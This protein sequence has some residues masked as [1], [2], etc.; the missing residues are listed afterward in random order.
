MKR[1]ADDKPVTKNGAQLRDYLQFLAYSGAREQ[2]ALRVRWSDV[3]LTTGRVTIGADGL[4]KNHLSRTV[5]FNAQLENLLREMHARRAPDSSW[6]FPSP[7]RGARDM[8]AKSFRESLK[9]ART[10]AKLPR[11]GFHDLRHMFA[12][13]CVMAGIDFMTIAAWMGHKDGGILVGKVYGHLLDA[14]RRNM[15]Q[16]VQFGLGR[17]LPREIALTLRIFPG[18]QL[19]P[20]AVLSAMTSIVFNRGSEL[21]GDR[22]REMLAIQQLIQRFAALSSTLRERELPL[23]LRDIAAQIRSMKRL[24]QGEGLADLLRRREAEAHGRVSGSLMDLPPCQ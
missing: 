15:A 18:I 14:H 12:S 8:H 19:F 5:E 6:L 1:T 7:Q 2:E 16:R 11:I 10:V 4:A 13:I 21:D 23:Y 17:N 24:W 9:L 3:D 20:P 22:R